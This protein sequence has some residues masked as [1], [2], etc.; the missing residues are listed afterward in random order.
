MADA[1]S[2]LAI[3]ERGR[4]EPGR[5]AKFL[6]KYDVNIFTKSNYKIIKAL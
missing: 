5:L 4:A 3:T 1:L 6:S 2:I